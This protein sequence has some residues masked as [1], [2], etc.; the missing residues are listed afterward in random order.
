MS[1]TALFAAVLL[2]AAEPPVQSYVQA[3]AA[4]GV[5]KGTMLAP[6]AVTPSTPVA[7]IVPGSGPTDRDGDGPTGL[8]AAPYRMLAEAL[9]QRGIASVRIDKRGMFASAAAGDPNAVTFQ[10][11]GDDVHAWAKVART[12]TGARCAWIIGHSEGALVALIAAQKSEGLCGLVLMTP[13]SVHVGELI[14]AQV[15]AVPGAQP[16]LPEVE[17]VLSQLKAGAR[18]DVTGLPRGLQ[19]LLGPHIQA[20]LIDEMRYEPTALLTRYDGPVLVI[21]GETDIQVPPDHARKLAAAR[22][23]AELR[24]I[25]GMNHV[26]KSAPATPAANAATYADPSL[27]LAPGVADAVADFIT[28]PGS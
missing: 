12:T 27:P 28:R 13:A 1:L 21:G 11:Y 20:F 23:G 16:I 8:K 14:R 19:M 22:A 5:L 25:P 3:E 2:A 15:A 26:L 24:I 9:A 17:R 7:V 18:A 4:G 10:Q 6:A